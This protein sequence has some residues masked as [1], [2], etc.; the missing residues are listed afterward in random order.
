MPVCEQHSLNFF[1]E[2]IWDQVEGR[3]DWAIG[4]NTQKK[5]LLHRYCLEASFNLLGLSLI[6]QDSTGAE[7]Q[8]TDLYRASSGMQMSG[9]ICNIISG[10]KTAEK[11]RHWTHWTFMGQRWAESGEVPKSVNE[12]VR[13]QQRERWSLSRRLAWLSECRKGNNNKTTECPSPNS[14]T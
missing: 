1:G 14:S 7:K 10:I 6:N 13:V 3:L 2:L 9:S 11:I 4:I 12:R 5:I 8:I